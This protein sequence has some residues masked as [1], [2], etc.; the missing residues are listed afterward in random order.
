MKELMDWAARKAK[1]G[2]ADFKYRTE[3]GRLEVAF[4]HEDGEWSVWYC[5]VLEHETGHGKP[6]KARRKA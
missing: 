2:K 4:V 3:G 6:S 1:K 5:T